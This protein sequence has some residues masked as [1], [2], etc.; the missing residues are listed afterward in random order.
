MLM[1]P[2][3][4]VT[5]CSIR[6]KSYKIGRDGCSQNAASLGNGFAGSHEIEVLTKTLFSHSFG[7]IAHLFIMKSLH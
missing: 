5:T 3:F 6:R 2:H 7:P 4:L 1:Q